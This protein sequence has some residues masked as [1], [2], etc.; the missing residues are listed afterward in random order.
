MQ[1]VIRPAVPGDADA[2]A[3]IYNHYVAGSCVTFE[4]DPVSG[5]EM[6]QRVADT[7]E[8][9]LPWLAAE[10]DGAIAGY[11]YASKWKGRCAYRYSVETTV[12]LDPRCTG[13]GL[14]RDLYAALIDAVKA[15]GMRAAIGGIA[16][17]NAASVALHER[18]GFRKVGHFE[19]VGFKQ[20]RWIDVGY[21]Q[22]LL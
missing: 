8:V 9:P 20:D 11:A 14:G 6:A 1:P 22:R 21:W 18:L 17:P 19:Q 5:T 7:L 13:R 3:R 10:A 15:L 16:L 12:Y 2:I 4:T